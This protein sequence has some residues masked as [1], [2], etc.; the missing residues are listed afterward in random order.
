MEKNIKIE[1]LIRI[2]RIN[3]EFKAS[4]IALNSKKRYKEKIMGRE[5]ESNK[6]VLSGEIIKNFV[7]NHECYGEKFY[8][9]QLAVDRLSRTKDI[10]PIMVSD[11]LVDVKADWLG[12]FIEISGYFQ[13]YNKY[14]SG[15]RKLLLSVFIDGFKETGEVPFID[16][17]NYIYLDG[18]IC[19]KPIYRKTILGREIADLL[20]AVNRP[21]GKSDYIPCI[22]WG[23]NARFA[24]GLEVGTRLQIEGRIQSREYI[25]KISDDE[26]ETRVTYEVTIQKMEETEEDEKGTD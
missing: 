18:F 14:E 9:A 1:Q 19:K 12:R 13:S 7:F 17:K 25:K 22:C 24:G 26:T 8:I 4:V 15:R 10:I 3:M 23:R 20:L 16:D 2:T 21:Y 5:I 11:R 6:V